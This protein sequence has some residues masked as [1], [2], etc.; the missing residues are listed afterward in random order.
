[1]P[2]LRPTLGSIAC[3][4]YG[5][6]TAF[7]PVPCLHCDAAHLRAALAANTRLQ[8]HRSRPQQLQ[9][10]LQGQFSLGKHA[11][12]WTVIPCQ[13]IVMIGLD[14]VYCV[15]AGKSMKYVWR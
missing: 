6:R 2:R 9:P 15:T 11:G 10:S 13:W 3:Q 4:Q 5:E 12:Y 1:M 7:G 14:I 8:P